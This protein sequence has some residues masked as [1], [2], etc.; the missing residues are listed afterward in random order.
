MLM[1]ELCMLA[2]VA[3]ARKRGADDRWRKRGGEDESWGATSY[4]IDQSVG[5][6]NVPAHAATG[7]G[8]RSLDYG[9]AV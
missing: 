2:D 9:D 8:E 4:G 3:Y 1:A 7:F 6:R 5:A